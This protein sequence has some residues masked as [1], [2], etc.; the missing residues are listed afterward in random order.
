M[1]SHF[2]QLFWGL[3]LVLLDFSINGFD[4]LPDG[5]GYLIVAAGCSGLSTLSPRFSTA[6]ILCFVLAIL[7]LVG[8]AIHRD[9]ATVYGL[10]RTLVN[11]A[12]I[13]Q[14]LGGIA[15]FAIDRG[16]RDLAERAHTRRVAYIAIMIATTLLTLIMRG[17]RD[18]GP[19]VIALVISILILMTM[20][21]HLIH[22]VKVELAN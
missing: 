7:W 20:I 9:I 18:A 5:L 1:K 21:L 3:L 17:S 22:R 12:F 14:L 4:I 15:E 16:R 11:C 10:A 8:F 6:R 2:S 13:W 19:L